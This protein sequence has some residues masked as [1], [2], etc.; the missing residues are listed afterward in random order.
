MAKTSKL[1][2][3]LY[4]TTVLV[5]TVVIAV[6]VNIIAG[7][8]FGRV[9]LTEANLNTLSQASRDAVRG[10]DDL[11]VTLYISPDFPET[12]R[13]EA[14]QPRVMRDVA[15]AFRDKI[16]EYRSYA[17]GSMTVREADGDIVEQAK[18][19]NLRAFSGEEATAKEG[20]LEFKQYVLGATFHYKDAM[21]VFPLG[22]YP[23]HY[24]FEITRLLTR[25]HDKVEH[26]G[27]MEDLLSA[28]KALDEAVQACDKA[29]A[30]AAPSED[31]GGANPFGL[32]TADVA[33]KRVG[34]YQ[35]AASDIQKACDGLTPAL[36]TAKARQGQHPALDSLIYMAD[37]FAQTFAQFQQALA[38]T[39]AEQKQQALQLVENLHAI[40]GEVVAEAKNLAD[41]PGRKSIGFICAGDA[42]CPFPDDT[43][44]VPPELAPVLGQKNPFAQQVVQ[45]LGL[46]QD[47]IN[48]VLGGVERNLFRRQGFDI[49]KVDLDKPV[50]TTVGG[51]VLFGARSAL[52]EHQLYQLDQYVL[53]GGSLVVFL[54]PWDVRVLNVTPKGEMTDT[55]MTKNSSNIGELLATW[56]IAPDG[57][58]V[59]EKTDHD[60]LNVLSV[61][62]QGQLAWQ[63][64]RQFPYPLLPVFHDMA[65]ESPLVRAIASLTLPWVEGLKLT[66]APGRTVTPLIR[67]TASAL[68]VSDPS[69]PLEPTAQLAQVAGATGEGPFVVAA[70]V[71]GEL[72]SHF[73][74]KDAP[75]A[76]ASEGDDKGEAKAEPAVKPQ[77][78]DKGEGRVLVI[79]SNLGLEPLSQGTI[80]KGFDL[81]ALT[82]GSFEII[83]QFQQWRANLQNW[84]VR[85][86]QIQHTLND[87]IQFL[88]NA[89]DWS[90]QQE[91]LVE[92]RSKQYQ[93]RPLQQLDE[94]QQ[95]IIKV[96]ATVGAPL[97]FILLGLIGLAV[98][99][100]RRR[101]LIAS[102]SGGSKA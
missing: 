47:R 37:A 17:N 74:G 57:G 40:K 48:Q 25:L 22:L 53:G 64:Q 90:I 24:E 79:G 38:A 26:A 13:D 1:T 77:R 43:P 6:L 8:L 73:A 34:A 55:G 94:G 36:A 18:K 59:A 51:L 76:P 32:L 87:N 23:E 83:D 5:A 42:F 56:G 78:R 93:R 11:E 67:S 92:I 29:L 98:R 89:L 69:F 100:G 3:G 27:E 30:D 84:E 44:L 39:E 82:N 88:F 63:T 72:P 46:M 60:V 61:V 41:S 102:M 86:S 16:E 66:D 71:T 33:E 80:F 20:R 35:T 58:L 68:S 62:R 21:E 9:D 85:L 28:G 19:A 12:I 81:A 91:A 45:Q 15:Q 54:N 14:G 7:R 75:P 10:F 95:S 101:R 99:R 52:T 49:A 31:D 65:T 4:V 2:G 96:A 50:P 70:T 97:L